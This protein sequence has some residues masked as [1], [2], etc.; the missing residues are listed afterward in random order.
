LIDEPA[1]GLTDGGMVQLILFV[2][3]EFKVHFLLFVLS[4]QSL[5]VVANMPSHNEATRQVVMDDS[6]LRPVSHEWLDHVT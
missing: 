3:M 2:T 1:K 6:C 5:M 4:L